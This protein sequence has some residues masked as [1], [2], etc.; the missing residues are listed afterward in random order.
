MRPYTIGIAGKGGTGKTTIA[1][2]LVRCLIDSGKGPVLA[3]DADPNANL[4]EAL[5]VTFHET[6]G[7][8]R[9]DAFTK[10]I[11][12]GMSRNDYIA[13]RFRKVLIESEGFDLIVMGRPEGTGCYCFA[14][15]LL[16]TA[17]HNLAKEYPF[18][19]IDN[20]AGMEHLAR[21][22]IGLPD[23]LL[24]VSDPGARGMRTAYRIRTIATDLG[25]ADDKI[26]LIVNRFQSDPANPDTF[27]TVPL[28]IAVDKADLAG[29][30]VSLIPKDSPA[31]QAVCKM[32]TNIESVF[33]DT[34]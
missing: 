9:E 25:M 3:V 21:G 18:I 32:M 22:T 4:H 30:P 12:P 24:I 27:A 17:M 10:S 16:T 20:E 19:I 14:N 2:L 28:D 26:L 15:D 6:L 11:P 13:L 8:M 23:I 7:S 33:R 29:E 5:G 1:S 34:I 31:R